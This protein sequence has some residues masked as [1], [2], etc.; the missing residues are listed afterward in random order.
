M[1]GAAIAA[2]ATTVVATMAKMMTMDRPL[3]SWLKCGVL[4]RGVAGVPSL[5]IRRSQ[6]IIP[7]NL[8]VTYDSMEIGIL[9][10]IRLSNVEMVP[11]SP[12]WHATI[13]VLCQN[14]AI[15]VDSHDP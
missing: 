11:K 10:P 2:A 13:A 4:A 8:Q 5:G 1:D 14:G 3:N 15:F 6:S 12:G 9:W 7:T